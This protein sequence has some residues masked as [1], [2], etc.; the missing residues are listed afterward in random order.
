MLE[1][2]KDLMAIKVYI[3]GTCPD[4]LELLPKAWGVVDSRQAL[5]GHKVLSFVAELDGTQTMG[6]KQKTNMGWM[7]ANFIGKHGVV[8]TVNLF[9]M[10]S[11]YVSLPYCS[12]Y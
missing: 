4:Q 8:D 3:L 5:V 12:K 7:V 9:T 1:Y 6:S 10:C 11:I 2:T